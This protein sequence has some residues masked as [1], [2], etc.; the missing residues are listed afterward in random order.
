[1]YQF[2]EVQIKGNLQSYILYNGISRDAPG[3]IGRLEYENGL[4]DYDNQR[5]TASFNVRNEAVDMY[6]EEMTRVVLVPTWDQDG[7]YYM[8][9][10]KVGIDQLSVE[11][12]RYSQE[13]ASYLEEIENNKMIVA[14]MQN[15]TASG[16][17]SSA[18]KLISEI[19]TTIKGF[20]GAAL[21]AGQ[22]Y[23][24]TRMNKCITAS[25][26]GASLRKCLV[27]SLVIALLFYVA[28]SSLMLA[29]RLPKPQ[30]DGI[31]VTAEP[32]PSREKEKASKNN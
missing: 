26:Y 29:R 20:A 31:Y 10:T 25:V 11:A 13:A 12:E 24:E 14:A 15:A 23:S 22:E 17:D 32:G 27:Y 2:N 8:G 21:A 16:S 3:Y 18:D 19:N 5:A 28:V 7:T 30:K 9:R 6:A 4:L 1:M